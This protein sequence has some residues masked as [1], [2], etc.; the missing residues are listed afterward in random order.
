MKKEIFSGREIGDIFSGGYCYYF[1]VMLKTA[2]N[3]GTVCRH[4][5]YGHIVWQDEDGIAYDINGVF[6]DYAE[7]DL[8]DV[9]TSLGDM[10]VDFKHNGAEYRA[11]SK[12]FHDWAEHYKMTD[13]CA[14]SDIYRN[15]PPEEIDDNET[16]VSM[17]GV[18]DAAW[19]VCVRWRKQLHKAAGYTWLPLF[20]QG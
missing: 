5:N 19:S 1:A 16:V 11:G 2:F 4:R 6:E 8:L 7:G 15:M 3:G 18:R 13:L 10:L 20:F 9:E 12:M 17:G 14:L